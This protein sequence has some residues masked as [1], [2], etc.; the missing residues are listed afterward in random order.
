M[1][2]VPSVQALETCQVQRKDPQLPDVLKRAHLIGLRAADG[3]F[4]KANG[5]GAVQSERAK[6]I[7]TV[8]YQK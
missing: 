7:P 8:I 1:A 4:T 2:P 5:L 6:L 3:V